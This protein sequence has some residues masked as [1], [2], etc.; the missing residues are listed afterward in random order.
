MGLYITPVHNTRDVLHLSPLL[1][2]QFEFTTAAREGYAQ[3]LGHALN[4]IGISSRPENLYCHHVSVARLPVV[5]KDETGDG[6][7]FTVESADAFSNEGIEGG[8]WRWILEEVRE[9]D[10]FCG[11]ELSLIVKS[12]A[13]PQFPTEDGRQR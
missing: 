13:N 2:E 4:G 8:S 6:T 1:H 12:V 11:K 5:H 9:V 3:V 10:A 7:V